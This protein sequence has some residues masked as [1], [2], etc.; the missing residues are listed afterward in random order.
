MNTLELAQELYDLVGELYPVRRSLTGP[1]VRRTLEI[2]ARYV[3]LDVVE[4]PSGTQV[5]DWTVP[6]EWELREGWIAT[7]DGVR[8]VDTSATSLRV[9]GYSVPVHAVLRRDELLDHVHVDPAAPEHIPYRTAYYDRTWGFCLTQRE[10]AALSDDRYEVRVDADRGPGHLIYGEVVLPGTSEAEVLLST[11]VCHPELANDNCS[12]I[13]VLALL[14]RRLAAR[15]RRLTYRLLFLPGTI[16]ALAWLH[17]NRARAGRIAHGLVVA[18]VGDPG[19]LTYQRTVH[20]AH[21]VDRAAAMVV[22]ARGGSLLDFSPWGY[23][24]R[25]FN[26]PG[27]RLPVGRLSRTPHGTYPE[28]HTSADDLSFVQPASLLDSLTALEEILSILEGDATYRNLAPYGEPQ[29]GRRGLYA[30]I[31]GERDQAEVKLAL[32][33]VLNQSDGT[34]SLLDVAQRSGLPFA[35]VAHAARLLLDA[36]LLERVERPQR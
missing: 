1:G 12:G 27:F 7:T 20:G 22:P 24:E 2:V 16:G 13:A 25:Q 8:V 19:P 21:P 26:A 15:D 11:H 6:D 3:P 9:L 18:G 4:V 14:G 32:L 30:G 36:G 23:D 28:Y 29:L 35:A 31:G 34:R 33:W 17:A 5:L 10:R